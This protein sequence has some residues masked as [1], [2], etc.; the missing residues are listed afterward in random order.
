MSVCSALAL[1]ASVFFVLAGLG[2]FAL[3]WMAQRMP[4]ADGRAGMRHTP[5]LPMRATAPAGS[6]P[7][8]PP[9]R[10]VRMGLHGGDIG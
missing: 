5:P 3:V 6:R 2:L 10:T 4:P 7:E 8:G 9:N 1:I